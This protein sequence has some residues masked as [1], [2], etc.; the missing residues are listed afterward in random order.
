MQ[1]TSVLYAQVHHPCVKK[2]QVK[3]C[4]VLPPE[5]DMVCNELF[6]NIVQIILEHP[7]SLTLNHLAWQQV[8]EWGNRASGA[9]PVA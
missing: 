2:S 9:S 6:L 3:F 5:L 7:V 1:F 8:S 4:I